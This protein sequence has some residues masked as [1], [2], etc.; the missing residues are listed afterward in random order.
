MNRKHLLLAAI[1]AAPLLVASQSYATG[2][3]DLGTA[4]NYTILA[5]SGISTTGTTSILG[6]I[7]VSPAAATS[8]TG[9]G[10][11]LDASG[12]FA[13]STLLVG[14]AFAADYTA[15]TPAKLTSAVSD[16]QTAY[17]DAAGRAPTV[18][19]LGAGTLTDL[20]LVPGVYKWT[21][22]VTIPTDLTLAGSAS[23]VWIF[24]IAGTL[25]IAAAK[26]V[27]LRG[28]AQPKNIF[29]Q[30]TGAVTLGMTSRFKGVILG[31]TGITM[32]TGAVLDGKALAQTA[33]TLQSNTVNGAKGVATLVDD[34]FA[35]VDGNDPDNNV[36]EV[37]GGVGSE[38]ASGTVTGV[39]TAGAIV[40]I[41]Y[42]TPAPTSHHTA[43][44]VLIKQ[45]KSS[46][47]DVQFDAVS[48]T[49]GPLVI[50]KCSVI[51]QASG[52]K[53]TGL[54][55]VN[56]KLDTVLTLMSANEIASA[57]TAFSGAPKVKFKVNSAGTKGSLTVRCKG[58]ATA[59]IP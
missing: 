41:S 16:M 45:V 1:A 19:E 21:S 24:Q 18:T 30:V 33:V 3:V 37:G 11:I 13:T 36:C 8:I 58:D 28:G 40:T 39:G 29:W 12:T 2:R 46:T 47:L 55:S 53:S 51:G 14:K 49:G 26:Q 43:K 4:G 17:T 52:A 20:T 57:K 50:E 59:I 48:T 44:K 31:Q 23:S 42:D 35:I 25:D 15:P 5:K 22:A 10:L 27:I 38:H 56:C 54:V 6:D 9:F 7:G 34:T 32:N